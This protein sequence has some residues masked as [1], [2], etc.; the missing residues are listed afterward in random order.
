MIP[1]L[2]FNDSSSLA[3][4]IGDNEISQEYNANSDAR[5]FILPDNTR[6]IK[7]FTNLGYS[8]AKNMDN[9][10]AI[11]RIMRRED[12][13]SIILPSALISLQGHIVGYEMDC[14]SGVDFGDALQSARHTHQQKIEWF[15]QL[16]GIIISL[17][18]GV[19]V[20]DLHA[21][22]VMVRNDN[23][24]VLVDI[25]G[26]SLENQHS[27]TGPAQYIEGLPSKYY[28]A[29]DTSKSHAKLI[30]YA[31]SDSFLDTF[32]ME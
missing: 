4:Y 2:Q 24:I 27:L 18:E 25:D 10:M 26:F 22:N 6:V 3:N 32:L 8:T 11:S 13:P 23:N 17:P 31:F 19:F 9:L 15:N 29:F 7:L 21:Q 14:V 5:L 28:D 1:V 20:G 16:A 12:Y 30:S